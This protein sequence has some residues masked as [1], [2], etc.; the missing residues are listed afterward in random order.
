MKYLGIEISNYLQPRQQLSVIN[1]R[2]EHYNGVHRAHP[3]Q[4]DIVSDLYDLFGNVDQNDEEES[5]FEL[6][7]GHQLRGVTKEAYDAL[8]IR[9]QVA[10]PSHLCRRFLLSTG[11]SHEAMIFSAHATTDERW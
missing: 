2:N 4:R 7:N 5:E 8:S 9:E 1:G 11:T 3:F 10:S 6:L